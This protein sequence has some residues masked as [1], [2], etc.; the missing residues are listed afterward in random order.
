M[1]LA[2]PVP[3]VSIINHAH[4]PGWLGETLKG[5]AQRLRGLQGLHDI[6]HQN[7]SSALAYHVDS[8][9]VDPI[10]QI[11]TRLLVGS[12]LC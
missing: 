11:A 7:I 4:A 2:L 1:A 5:E 9:A 10:G 12:W 3:P 8:L 6:S